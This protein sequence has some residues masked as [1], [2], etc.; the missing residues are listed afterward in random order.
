MHFPLDITTEAANLK[1]VKN[2]QCFIVGSYECKKESLTVER[3][4]LIT[5]RDDEGRL[6][7]SLRDDVDTCKTIFQS[8]DDIIHKRSHLYPRGAV[9]L[10]DDGPRTTCIGIL[11]FTEEGFI[12]PVFFTPETFTG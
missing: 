10:K 9:I 7:H 4:T 11:N 3:F 12:S 2:K 1:A 5:E 8:Y 6:Q